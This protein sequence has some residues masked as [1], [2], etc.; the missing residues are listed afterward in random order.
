MASSVASQ[1]RRKGDWLLYILLL[2]AVM[3]LPLS[4]RTAKWVPE[5]NRLVYVA[6]WASLTG[7]VL[8]RSALPAWLARLL[9]T[10]LGAE[11]S[12][13]FAGKLLPDLGLL[14]SETGQA[15]TWLWELV[16]NR[17][18]GPDLPFAGSGSHVLAQATEMISN[19]TTWFAA[20]E[21]GSTS[22]DNT[23][24]WLGVSFAVWLLAWQAGFELFRSRRT[25][26]ALLPLGIG[27]VL[28]VAFT[29][30]GMSY[31]HYY[32]GATLFTLVWA[33]TGRVEELWGRLGVDFSPELRRDAVVAGSVLTSLVVVVALTVPYITF[34]RAAWY[35]WEK[36]E[37]RLKPFYEQLDR[38]FAG[39]NPVPEPTPGGGR[40]FPA[41]RIASGS[42]P[43]TETVLLVQTSDPVPLP[44][45]MRLLEEQLEMTVPKHYWRQRAYDVYTGHGW[46][47][48]ERSVRDLDGDEPW[49]RIAFPHQVLTQTFQLVDVVGDFSFAVNEPIHVDQEYQLVAR[50][51]G[52]FVAL[53]VR[54]D[55]Y[56]VVSMVPD[57][58]VE[59]LQGAEQEYPDWVRERYLELP[60]IP[61]RVRQA[62][63]QVVREAGATTRYEKARAI[64]SYLR[65]FAY[66]LDLE[67]PPLDTDVVDYFLFSA[68]RGYCDYSATAMVVMLRS[69]GVSA[70]YASGFNMGVYDHQMEAWVVSQNNAH[71]WVEVYFPGY[72]WI[73]FEPTPAQRMFERAQSRFDPSGLDL[74]PPT[75]ERPQGIPLLWRWA[76]VLF[77]LVVLAIVWPPRWFRR[78]RATPRQAVWRVYDRLQRRARWL[79][80]APAEGQTPR[81]YLTALASE[82]E[83]RAGFARGA[84]K[85]IILIEQVYQR[86]RYSQDPIT[87]GESDRA[88][89]AWR[90]LRGKLFRLVFVGVPE[91][92]AR[93]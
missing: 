79:G 91:N 15:P 3:C 54:S 56:T 8:A 49:T 70:R 28:S 12:V 77:L 29:D 27:V 39:R 61:D 32:L 74:A 68:K 80:L 51:E 24:L 86:A 20:V 47:T 10:L 23:A 31:V 4:T 83:R 50:G 22:R 69:V 34:A 26:A 48:S 21:S 75:Q 33:N 25:F 58:T 18:V 67:P 92:P 46:D 82:V 60:K 63:E 41:H 85:D 1:V 2:S 38:A 19:L 5:G 37:G 59:E 72:G 53:W 7:V 65:G 64:E 66:D 71:A 62:A 76:A 16:T 30:I 84:A 35:F 88:G 44:E 45:E 40:G 73:E 42:L 57:A 9:G 36:V 89:D 78:A 52:D 90:R 93:S 14:V 11:Y 87:F 17:S 55:V 81:E 13:Q 6:F 43:G